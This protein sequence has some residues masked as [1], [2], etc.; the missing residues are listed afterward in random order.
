MTCSIEQLDSVLATFAEQDFAPA[1]A[2]A[3]A[4]AGSAGVSISR[5]PT[6]VPAPSL[7]AIY[8]R[9]AGNPRLRAALAAQCDRLARVAAQFPDERWYI[10]LVTLGDRPQLA[11][12]ANERG[13]GRVCLDHAAE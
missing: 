1:V 10:Y 6:A 8:A 11:I 3:R 7:E 12:F 5:N 2:R 13:V 9:R 4:L